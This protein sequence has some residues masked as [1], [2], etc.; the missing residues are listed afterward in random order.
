MTVIEKQTA[1]KLGLSSK[2][3]GKRDAL[4]AVVLLS[5]QYTGSN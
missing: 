5:Q 4:D 2:A 3:L 1:E